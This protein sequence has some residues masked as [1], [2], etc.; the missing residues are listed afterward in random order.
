MN[1]SKT[2]PILTTVQDCHRVDTYSTAQ[3]RKI[4]NISEWLVGNERE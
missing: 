4:R 1:L 2:D 3:K